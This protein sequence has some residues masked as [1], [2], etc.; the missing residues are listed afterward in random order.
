[1]LVRN[2]EVNCWKEDSQGKATVLLSWSNCWD[3][4]CSENWPTSFYKR[5]GFL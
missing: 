3:W 4:D 2:P 5:D 1:V